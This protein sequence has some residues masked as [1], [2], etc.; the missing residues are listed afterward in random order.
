MTA[1]S[2]CLPHPNVCRRE[3]LVILFQLPVVVE[4]VNRVL[5]G[6]IDVEVEWTGA[7]LHARVGEHIVECTVTRLASAIKGGTA[8]MTTTVDED[9][10]EVTSQCFHVPFT[11]LDTNECTLPSN[12]PMRHACAAPAV[13]VNT[14]GSYECVC[15]STQDA[16][17]ILNLGSKSTGLIFKGQAIA[18]VVG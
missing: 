8:G 18:A 11:I 13:C 5:E 9:G 15:P 3:S 17:K 10:R 16:A 4:K 2:S 7:D 6:V 14:I 1:S 12:H